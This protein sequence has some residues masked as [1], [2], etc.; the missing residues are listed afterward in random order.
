MLIKPIPSIHFLLGLLAAAGLAACAGPRGA[1]VHDEHHPGQSGAGLSGTSAQGGMMGGGMTRSHA[2]CGMMGTAGSQSAC[3]MMGDSK[4]A[5]TG[6]MQPMDKGTMCSMYRGM[7][8][9]PDDQARQ[10]MSDRLMPRMAPEMRQRHLEMM[11]Q[12]CQ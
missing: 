4:A 1:R 6:A 12:Q 8:D 3:A 7:R 11:R 2:G 5:G 10:A 9:A